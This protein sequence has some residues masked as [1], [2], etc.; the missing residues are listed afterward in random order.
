MRE[1]SWTEATVE[2]I[3]T[4]GEMVIEALTTLGDMTVFAW[5]SFL[6]SRA[7]AP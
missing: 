5:Q 2:W 1:P 6:P 3:S 7:K 4:W